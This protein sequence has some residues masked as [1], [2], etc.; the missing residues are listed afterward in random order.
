V[1]DGILDTCKW[2][3]DLACAD[4]LHLTII[5]DYIIS[6]FNDYAARKTP[7][8]DI[9]LPTLHSVQFTCTLCVRVA[10][11]VRLTFV[12]CPT[13]RRFFCLQ[14]RCKLILEPGAGPTAHARAPRSTSSNLPS[15]TPSSN[16]NLLGSGGIA[17]SEI[18]KVTSPISTM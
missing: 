9:C 18:V 11:L 13:E 3:R 5:A 15:T 7:P 6:A 17:G 8:Y 4:Q 12:M 1:E 14:S 16:E 10:D 2:Y